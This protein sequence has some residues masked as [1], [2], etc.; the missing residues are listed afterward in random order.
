M[1][2]QKGFTFTAGRVKNQQYTM[3]IHVEQSDN[4]IYDIEQQSIF[5]SPD[6]EALRLK[7]IAQVHREQVMPFAERN[8]FAVEIY[9]PAGTSTSATAV[10]ADSLRQ[11]LAADERVDN[12]TA[13]IGCASPR[14]HTAYAP[15]MGGTNYAQFIVN[16]VNEE[17]TIEMLDTYDGLF[18]ATFPQAHIKFKQLSYNEAVCP[19]E[20]RLS[21][22]NIDTLRNDTRKVIRA[23]QQVDGLRLIRSNYN[24]P[25]PTTT[26]RLR[27]DEASR[28]GITNL[29]LEA[30]LSMRY[31][32]STASTQ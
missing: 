13:F 8:Q 21:H 23:L 12:I 20:I 32:C 30:T 9:M 1:L 19:I 31:N 10:V 25:M 2:M 17:A 28:L 3:P 6:G 22:D 4:S 5:T 16:T 29:S 27:E 7:D 11:L 26:I 18:D 15:Q 24:E 14:F